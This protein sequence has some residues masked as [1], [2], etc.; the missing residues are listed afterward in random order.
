M[1]WACNNQLGRRNL[2]PEQQTY[3]IGKRLE[4]EKL[5]YGARDGFRGNQY[6]KTNEVVSYQ[7]GILPKPDPE[8]TMPQKDYLT[9]KLYENVK[10]SA[11]EPRPE[12]PRGRTAERLA[13]E[14]GVGQGTVNRAAD[15][16]KGVDIAEEISPGAKDY[17]L[18]G[19]IKRGKATIERLPKAEP[20]K[21]KKAVK[22]IMEVYVE[23]SPIIKAA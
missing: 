5:S 4:N 17:I 11:S 14:Y 6:S 19:E 8:P 20:E 18:S 10:A 13:K 3:L 7:N 22:S 1:A 16:A 21:Q 12:P 2:T 9:G 23:Y 15:F